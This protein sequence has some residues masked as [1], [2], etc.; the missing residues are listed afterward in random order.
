MN[1]IIL[2]V[3]ANNGESCYN[4][5]KRGDIV[6]AFEPTPDLLKKHL[7]SKQSEKYIVIPK[8]VSDFDGKAE[9]NISPLRGGGCSSLYEFS[10]DLETTWKGRTDF[11]VSE[12]ISVE[13]TRIDTFIEENNI[14]EISWMHCDTQGNDLKVLQSFGKYLNLLKAGVVEVCSKNP[15]YKNASNSKESVLEFL[16]ENGFTV[17]NISSN[18]PYNN[19]LNV[20]FFKK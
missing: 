13:V 6:Y 20:E 17:K 14:S 10:D 16:N 3:G 9:F 4:F 19:E 18:D 8:A 7:L 12:T 11:V 15:L 5:T 2:D 1:R